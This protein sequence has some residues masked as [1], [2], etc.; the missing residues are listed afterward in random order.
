MGD[1]A[2]AVLYPEGYDFA[3]AYAEYSF[4]N[5]SQPTLDYLTGLWEDYIID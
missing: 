3:K 4:K 5:L 1:E 2:L